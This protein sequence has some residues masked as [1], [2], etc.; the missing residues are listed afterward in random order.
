MKENRIDP[1]PV[2]LSTNL[3]IDRQTPKTG[4][5]DRLKSGLETAAGVVAN[6]AAVAAPFV[7]GGA[8]VS[9]AVS[10]VSQMSNGLS[11]GQQSAMSASYASTVSVPGGGGINTTVGGVLPTGTGSGNSS[12]PGVGSTV[13]GSPNYLQGSNTGGE[14]GQMNAYLAQSQADAAKLLSVQMKMQHESQ[15]FTSVSN[16]LKTRHETVKNTISNVR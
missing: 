7:P 8:I 5:G 2:R 6:G 9:A 14:S 10:S 3:S 4:F 12:L 15:V 13:G 1:T 16:V 11:S